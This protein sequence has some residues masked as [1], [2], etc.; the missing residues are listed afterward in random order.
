MILPQGIRTS[1]ATV[2]P[3]EKSCQTLSSGPPSALFP[4]LCIRYPLCHARWSMSHTEQYASHLA[5]V[6]AKN[7]RSHQGL[8]GLAHGQQLIYEKQRAVYYMLWFVQMYLPTR[9][10]SWVG[11]RCI[12]LP[13]GVSRLTSPPVAY[14][15]P[16]RRC[17]H[18]LPCT[19]ACTYKYIRT[20][21]CT[22]LH[23]A[24]LCIKPVHPHRFI[25]LSVIHYQAP[26]PLTLVVRCP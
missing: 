20:V 18:L 25:T 22:A 16:D 15:L 5:L 19:A 4:T 1:T 14:L 8:W 23:G 2:G 26:R 21:L 13:Y 11:S 6:W 12:R 9:N 17:L 3:S 7:D 24:P 10:T